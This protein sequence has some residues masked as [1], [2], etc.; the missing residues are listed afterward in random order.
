MVRSVD[1]HAV[2]SGM[3]IVGICGMYIVA[4]GNWGQDVWGCWWQRCFSWLCWRSCGGGIKTM[5]LNGISTTCVVWCSLI[6]TGW[7][8]ISHSTNYAR[9]TKH[10]PFHHKYS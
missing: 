1:M 10:P 3:R 6:K 7:L 9:L 2:G 5:C 4:S 8:N